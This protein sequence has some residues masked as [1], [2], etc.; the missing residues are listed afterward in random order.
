MR[1][2]EDKAPLCTSATQITPGGIGWR[3]RGPVCSS[4]RITSSISATLAMPTGGEAEAQPG[5]GER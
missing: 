4:L 5:G 2:A 3:S 1:V